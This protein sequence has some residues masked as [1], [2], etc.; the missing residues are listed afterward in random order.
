MALTGPNDN[1]PNPIDVATGLHNWTNYYLD[2]PMSALQS[3][4]RGGVRVD[5]IDI[6]YNVDAQ[7][8]GNAGP[9]TMA[10]WDPAT[11]GNL[12][13]CGLWWT[14]AMAIKMTYD[15]TAYRNSELLA[16][17]G[18]FE[19]VGLPLS[20]D[21]FSPSEI[22]SLKCFPAVYYSRHGEAMDAVYSSGYGEAMNVDPVMTVCSL[23]ALFSFSYVEELNTYY[24][25]NILSCISWIC[26][27]PPSFLNSDVGG[28]GVRPTSE[29]IIAYSLLKPT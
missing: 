21:E 26:N 15:D 8:Q 24:T 12:V 10:L 13:T 1:V 23:D 7:D 20:A 11:P 3:C 14:T 28:V 6:C 5:C 25:P 29:T 27:S 17:F 18:K 22:P 9:N 2:E 19:S 16:E 4:T